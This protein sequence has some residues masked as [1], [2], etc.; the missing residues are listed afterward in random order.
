MQQA[1]SPSQ[2]AS[3]L[4]HVTD[5][6][7]KG[8]PDVRQLLKLKN[9]LSSRSV[10][11][12]RKD[13][14]RW[15]KVDGTY[16]FI[17]D[18]C[19]ADKGGEEEEDEEKESKDDEVVKEKEVTDEVIEVEW[20]ADRGKKGKTDRREKNME[21][22]E[23]DDVEEVDSSDSSSE[24]DEPLSTS[25][26]PPPKIRHCTLPRPVEQLDALTGVVLRRYE[27]MKHAT[28]IMKLNSGM[29]RKCCVDPTLTT[30][31]FKWRESKIPSSKSALTN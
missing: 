20:C 30:G 2:I 17:G 6:I 10:S 21:V 3:P 24:E 13:L 27:S 25:T 16:K 4:F 8:L 28:R 22:I 19:S 14:L 29:V 9:E 23:V 1:Q 11:D 7:N 12:K 26:H 18:V 31:N 5:T 15:T